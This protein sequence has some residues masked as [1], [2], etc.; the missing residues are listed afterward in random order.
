[1]YIV[2]FCACAH[3]GERVPCTPETCSCAAAEQRQEAMHEAER[4]AF[5]QD[6]CDSSPTATA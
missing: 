2:D 1:M 3:P 6:Q 5:L 4:I